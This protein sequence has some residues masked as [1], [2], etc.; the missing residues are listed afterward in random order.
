MA[1]TVEIEETEIQAA[2]LPEEPKSGVWYV[3]LAW[4][5]GVFGVHSFYAGHFFYRTGSAY[6]D[7]YVMAVSVYPVADYHGLGVSGYVVCQQGRTGG[8]FFRQ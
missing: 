7:D 8:G 2:G 5:L 4:F 6:F 3:V 1:K